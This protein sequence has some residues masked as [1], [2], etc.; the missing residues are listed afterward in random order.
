MMRT[1][2]LQLDDNINTYMETAKTLYDEELTFNTD[3]WSADW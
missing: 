2:R 3:Q 1:I